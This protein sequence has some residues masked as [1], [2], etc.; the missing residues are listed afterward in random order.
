MTLFSKK[1]NNSNDNVKYSMNR[2]VG[3]SVA[4]DI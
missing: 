4:S 3:V 1:L 2:Q